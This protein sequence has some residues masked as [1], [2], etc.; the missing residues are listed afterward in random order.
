[1]CMLIHGAWA[2]RSLFRDFCGIAFFVSRWPEAVPSLRQ[3]QL[4]QPPNLTGTRGRTLPIWEK[5]QQ[6]GFGDKDLSALVVYLVNK[7]GTTR[8]K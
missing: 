6:F 2:N 7:P 1:M 8:R 4:G 3:A 5:S